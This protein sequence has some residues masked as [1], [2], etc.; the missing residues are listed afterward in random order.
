VIFHKFELQARIRKQRKKYLVNISE[1]F[2]S[3][4]DVETARLEIIK[5]IIGVKFELCYKR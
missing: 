1:A 4:E 2:Y 5:A 3:S